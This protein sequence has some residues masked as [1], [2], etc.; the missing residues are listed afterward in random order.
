MSLQRIDVLC[1]TDT[2]GH[3]TPLRFTYQQR[4]FEIE[5]IGRQ[6]SD[7]EGT[8]MLVMTADQKVFELILARDGIQW[9]LN[10][11]RMPRFPA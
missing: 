10:T 11:R 3:L 1:G 4:T 9:Y 2:D 7:D 6:W 8:H 5:D